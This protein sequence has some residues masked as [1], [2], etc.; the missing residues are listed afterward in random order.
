M[1]MGVLPVSYKNTDLADGSPLTELDKEYRRF[2]I[3]GYACQKIMDAV[4][5]HNFRVLNLRTESADADNPPNDPLGTL[6]KYPISSAFMHV[7]VLNT[8]ARRLYERYGYTERKRIEN[9]Y[10]RRGADDTGIKDAW[11]LEKAIL[12]HKN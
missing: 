11:V 7:Y 2:A 4:S 8:G 1:L 9:F 5:E 3:G 12:L 6:S 10:R